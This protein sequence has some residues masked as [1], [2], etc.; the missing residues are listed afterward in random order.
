MT[1]TRVGLI[2][3]GE[4]EALGFAVALQRLWPVDV[5]T[6]EVLRNHEDEMRH[7][8]EAFTTSKVSIETVSALRA[9]IEAVAG[10]RAARVDAH[11]DRLVQGVFFHCFPLKRRG[12]MDYVVVIDD[13]ELVN[14]GNERAVLDVVRA[15]VERAAALGKWSDSVRQD[16]R[17][18]AS[19]HLLDP[20]LEAYFFASPSSL[21]PIASSLGRVIPHPQLVQGRSC[22]RFEVSTSDAPFFATPGECP[23]FR[24][25]EDRK[26]PWRA[27]DGQSLAE[28]PKKYLQY[29]CRAGAPNGFCTD[30]RETQEGATAL[31]VLDWAA[32]FARGAP[33][34]HALIEDLEAM[35]G[36]PP[37]GSLVPVGE[38]VAL[39]S[40]ASREQRP[41]LDRVLRNV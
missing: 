6:F 27:T 39:T 31:R 32:V 35:L 8:Y 7:K 19:F 5:A 34:L 11:I 36:P 13:L 41:E 9:K 12:A 2:V 3:T 16:V 30:Y 14:R 23:R 29:L 33:Y 28:H 17:E 24:K 25:S 40:L 37:S 18:R 22:E 21:T 20:M 26:C 1:A 4:A 15:A 10:T 38:A